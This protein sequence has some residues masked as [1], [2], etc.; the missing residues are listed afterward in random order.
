VRADRIA[1]N[2]HGQTAAIEPKTMMIHSVAGRWHD[3]YRLEEALA[4][5]SYRLCVALGFVHTFGNVR[6]GQPSRLPKMS[7]SPV[8]VTVLMCD[9]DSIYVGRAEPGSSIEFGEHFLLILERRVDQ[10]MKI[11]TLYQRASANCRSN[12]TV[13]AFAPVPVS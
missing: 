9:E 8:V 4:R 6:T 1:S 13:V 3:I 7:K 12:S 11:I 2:N 5:G 10:N